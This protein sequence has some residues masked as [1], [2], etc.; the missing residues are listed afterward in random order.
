VEQ[1]NVIIPDASAGV[2]DD[3]IEQAFSGCE[4]SRFRKKKTKEKWEDG[5]ILEEGRWLRIEAYQNRGGSWSF[6]LEGQL[7]VFRGTPPDDLKEIL[8]D[9]IKPKYHRKNF[10]SRAEAKG[11]LNRLEQAYDGVVVERTLRET[12][13]PEDLLRKCENLVSRLQPFM[14]NNPHTLDEVADLYE[15]TYGNELKP[16]TLQQLLSLMI[17]KYK[18]KIALGRQDAWKTAVNVICRTYGFPTGTFDQRACERYDIRLGDLTRARLEEYVAITP[19]KRAV[20]YVASLRAILE[21]G[22]KEHY[23]RENVAR[24]LDIRPK[25]ADIAAQADEDIAVHTDAQVQIALNIAA[26]YDPG[27]G[28]GYFVPHVVFLYYAAMRPLSELRRFKATEVRLVNK[29]IR[30]WSSKVTM[31]RVIELPAN[32]VAML[33]DYW[34]GQQLSF[35]GWDTFWRIVRA[36]Q[37]YD[38][39]VPTWF[40]PPPGP[41][42]PWVPDSPRHTGSSHHR[43]WEP[44]IEEAGRWTGHSGSIFKEYYDGLVTKCESA[45]FFTLLP[46]SMPVTEEIRAAILKSLVDHNLIPDGKLP[47]A[48]EVPTFDVNPP[49]KPAWLPQ[50]SDAEL[51]DRI[52]ASNITTVAKDLGTDAL[53]LQAVCRA[54]CIP[55][56]HAGRALRGS[57][58]SAPVPP[59]LVTLPKAELEA[60][61]KD[62]HGVI[63]AARKLKIPP[64]VLSAYCVVNNIS[65]PSHREIYLWYN[66]RPRVTKSPQQL[67][68]MLAKATLDEVAASMDVSSEQLRR[69]CDRKGVSITQ[70]RSPRPSEP[71]LEDIKAAVAEEISKRI[72]KGLKAHEAMELVLSKAPQGLKEEELIEVLGAIGI[73]FTKAG[74]KYVVTESAKGRFERRLGQVRLIDIYEPKVDLD[75]LKKALQN[76]AQESRERSLLDAIRC[77]LAKT[78]AGISLDELSVVLPSLGV[79]PT[80]T[81]L[82]ADVRRYARQGRLHLHWNIV[83]L[84]EKPADWTIRAKDKEAT[85]N[86]DAIKADVNRD[87]A[88]LA[89]RSFTNVELMEFVLSKAPQGLWQDEFLN[90]AHSLGVNFKRSCIYSVAQHEAKG[91]FEQR[92]GRLSLVGSYQPR[93]TVDDI[94]KALAADVQTATGLTHSQLMLKLLGHFPAGLSVNE[95]MTAVAFMGDH[96]SRQT[97]RRQVY[98]MARRGQVEVN[99]GHARLRKVA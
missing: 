64:T 14:K 76:D 16:I 23:I 85:P 50:I 49:K 81:A 90:L 47:A 87:F 71:S 6:R 11:M 2:V 19:Y 55:V 75:Q 5:Q 65:V 13:L 10:P 95:L 72:Y 77:V 1:P 21:Y 80:K 45:Q 73:P 3:A 97:L 22:R 27:K 98:R 4:N 38:I 68:V 32:A 15:R 61:L 36:A 94:Q 44:D 46:N 84:P 24:G 35:E 78:P 43:W 63:P 29:V 92:N 99:G 26:E 41:R 93:V 25:Q 48:P 60:I 33:E 83:S 20:H 69:Y 28:K 39:K 79:D 53:W 52:W 51:R 91:R 42:K 74:I 54:K 70:P 56:P 67:R 88:K 66:N 40:T 30:L 34:D 57:P 96:P 12:V 18:E 58:E 62:S 31:R 89:D 86:L 7:P 37:G 59:P 17:A 8:T 9:G 82:K